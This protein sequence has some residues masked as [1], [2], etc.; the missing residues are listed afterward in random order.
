MMAFV[1]CISLAT[2]TKVTPPAASV[3]CLGNF[4]GVHLAHRELLN[5]AKKLRSRLSADTACGVF[6]FSASPA[7][8]LSATPPP[9]LCTF[10]QKLELFYECGMEYAFV[11]DF[12]SVKDLSPDEFIQTV[13]KEQCNCVG[14]VCG[15]NF[16][17]GR[18][19]AGSSE[20][21][22]RSLYAPVEI[23][24]AILHEGE[25]ISSTR[26]RKLLLE[27]DA[28]AAAS[29]LGRPYSFTSPVI[30]GKHLGHKLGAP[31]INQQIPHKMLIPAYG[32]YVTEC[33]IEGERFRAVTNVG[34]RPTVEK[35]AGVNCESY[36]LNFEGD[37][38]EK[39]ITTYFL[40]R[41]RPEKQFSSQED[42]QAQIHRDIE[43]ARNY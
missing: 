23:Q 32:V 31:T 42:L 21:L 2:M 6:C 29:L 20:L 24:E 12:P 33:E 3:L 19:G 13:L 5:S 9:Q 7:D 4:D 28:N 8:Y 11:A 18:K 35:N 14:A 17:F 34:V 1:S 30:H 26:I 10:E 39:N 15:F 36:L 27:G 40:E 16:R 37:L 22:Q 25:P 43:T 38:Y 41:I